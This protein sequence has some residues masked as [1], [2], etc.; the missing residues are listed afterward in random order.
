MGVKRG[1]VSPIFLTLPVVRQ[2]RN[3]QLATCNLLVNR[4]LHMSVGC[5]VA[6]QNVVD[7]R[8][9][10]VRVVS[11]HDA[12]GVRHVNLQRG[13]FLVLIVRLTEGAHP[14]YGRQSLVST[15][16]VE[17]LHGSQLHGL[18]LCYL[19]TADVAG[20]GSTQRSHE[21]HDACNLDA[22]L[23]QPDLA[24]LPQVPAGHGHH[25][26]STDDPSGDNRVAELADGKRRECY[27]KERHH[28]VTHGVRIELA[29]H[30][31]LHPGISHKNP[32]CRDGGSQACQPGGGQVE[33]P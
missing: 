19:L 24:L 7:A 22:L 23:S 21:A 30:R 32:P 8:H 11:C 28:L 16:I 6:F 26:D 18:G 14:G 9:E 3:G 13:F 25:K 12:Q 27:L 10:T 31:T 15:A 1:F 5:G 2:G 4:R 20:E 29:A 33:A 17:R